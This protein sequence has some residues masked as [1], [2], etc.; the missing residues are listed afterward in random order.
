MMSR[1]F[2]R[3]L[4]KARQHPEAVSVGGLVV[5]IGALYYNREAV[6][7]PIFGLHRAVWSMRAGATPA[8]VHSDRKAEIDDLLRNLDTLEK[9]Q[10]IVVM[11]GKGNGKSCLIQTALEN[12]RGVVNV[13]VS[14]FLVCVGLF[15]ASNIY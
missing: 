6:G 10:Y 8:K 15:V 4:S 12:M 2:A 3:V 13:S 1:M 11:G 14:A 5:S 9:G 7:R